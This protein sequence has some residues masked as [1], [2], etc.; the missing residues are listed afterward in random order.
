MDS[1]CECTV[2]WLEP[3]LVSIMEDESTLAVPVTDDINAETFQYV[4][5]DYNAFAVAVAIGRLF[6]AG[7]MYHV[8]V[9]SI[10]E[11]YV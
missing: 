8:P 1:H 2:G 6:N 5:D 4:C 9:Y 3:L 10:I 11:S 7:S